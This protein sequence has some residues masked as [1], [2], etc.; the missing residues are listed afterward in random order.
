MDKLVKYAVFL[1]I[2]AIAIAGCNNAVDNNDNEELTSLVG[3]K[4]KL[5][6]I[7]DVKTNTLKVLEPK[8]CQRCYII[9]F[10]SGLYEDDEYNTNIVYYS[11]TNELVGNY[12]ANYETQTISFRIYGGTK[13]GEVGDGEMWCNI[14]PTIK[15][16]SFQKNSLRLYYNDQRNYL[17][18]KMQDS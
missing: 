12:N 3:T 2:S 4:W 13:V 6:G 11:S 14:F 8:N 10:N 15:S 5:V 16:F 18:F 17:L 9:M 7:M 1:L